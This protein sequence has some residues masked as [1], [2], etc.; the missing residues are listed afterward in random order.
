MWRS[1]SQHYHTETKMWSFWR[2]F[3]TGYIGHCPNDNFQ[4]CSLYDKKNVKISI[5]LFPCTSS[6]RCRSEGLCYL[7]YQ[8]P[9]CQQGGCRS[10]CNHNDD[11]HLDR[12]IFCVGIAIAGLGHHW[13]NHDVLDLCLP[14]YC[15]NYYHYHYYYY[16]YYY[17]YDN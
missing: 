10:I 6:N 16:H 4:W 13:L 5:F 14:C 12:W 11:S 17:Y 9:S 15:D 3:V 1:L 7:G 2:M 8:L